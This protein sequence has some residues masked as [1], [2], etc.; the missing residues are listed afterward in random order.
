MGIRD[1]LTG[2]LTKASVTA[3]PVVGYW[4]AGQPIWTPDNYEK[5]AREGYRKSVYVYRAV[6]LVAQSCAGI[7]WLLYRA[8]SGGE[9]DEIAEHPL[10]DLLS[11]PNPMQGGAQLIESLIA[12]RLLA[13]NSYIEKVSPDTGPNRRLPRELYALRPDRTRIVVGTPEA[14]V[15]AYEYTVSG[16]PVRLDATNVLHWKTFNP[17][18]DWYGMP[19]LVAAA[20][21]VDQN[22]S[23][24]DH[25][26]AMHQNA[27]RPSGALMFEGALA[28]SQKKN[29]STQI[30]KAWAGASNAGKVLLLEKGMTWQSMGLSP[31]DMDWLEG[32]KLSADEIVN[33]FGVSMTLLRPTESSFA[34]MAQARKGFYQDTV[35]PLMDNL[36]DELNRWLVPLYGPDLRLEIDRDSI[37]ALQE[38][39]DAVYKRTTEA[40]G[41]GYLTVNE[42]RTSLGFD[43]DQQF[44]GLYGWQIEVIKRFGSLPPGFDGPAPATGQPVK[45]AKA[46]GLET[47]EQRV[48]AYK[49]MERRRE[50]YYR[51][52]AAKVAKRFEAEQAA[53]IAAID[54]AGDAALGS[55]IG[56]VLEAQE[57]EWAKLLEA[58]Y[59][60]VGEDFGKELLG[61]LEKSAGR[62]ERKANDRTLAEIYAA[63]RAYFQAS[64]IDRIKKIQQT[65]AQRLTAGLAKRRQ[66]ETPADVVGKV[67]EGFLGHRSDLIATSEVVTAVGVGQGAAASSSDLPLIDEWVST[68]DGKV[69]DTH[70][71]ADGQK[72]KHGEPFTVGGYRLMHPGDGSL[73]APAREVVRCRCFV[74]YD[75]DEEALGGGGG[76]GGA[77]PRRPT[78]GGGDDQERPAHWIRPDEVE[79]WLADSV[80]KQPTFHRTTEAHAESIITEGVDVT[81]GRGTYGQGFYTALLPVRDAGAAEISV[82][83]RTLNPVVAVNQWDLLRQ[84]NI[85]PGVPATAAAVRQAVI[86]AG[87]DGII[88]RRA[89]GNDYAIAIVDGTARTIRE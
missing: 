82:A 76:G 3:G 39:R 53:V 7:P 26:V 54:G 55:L 27:A 32:Q 1:W 28:D 29:L 18:D 30:K 31:V 12:Y 88:I 60:S 9:R 41:A 51:A 8:R 71:A 17:L 4:G 37:E 77:G 85:Q 36:A 33:A 6:N 75:L 45:R 86:D 48:F 61:R 35:L 65:T 80:V 52:V 50:P 5:L 56:G 47:E 21:S 58:V 87:Y 42:A 11:R 72:V 22:N 78:G 13:G 70:R 34:N 10:L 46:R 81:R 64:V 69:R 84:I 67:Y 38:E 14:P 68:R 49:A 89:D 20:R 63:I 66:G 24:K 73:G 74:A 2:L 23:A 59:L 15:S 83:I 44:G 19:P 16:N 25:N 62:P 40:F 43:D 57:A 79:E